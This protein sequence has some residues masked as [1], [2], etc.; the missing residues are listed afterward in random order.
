VKHGVADHGFALNV[1]TKLEYFDHITA[2]GIKDIKMG[3]LAN[4][5]GRGILY[6]DFA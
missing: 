3:S 2:C 6:E 4:E 5:I 1:N